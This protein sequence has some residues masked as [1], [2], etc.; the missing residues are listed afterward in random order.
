MDYVK[1]AGQFVESNV[2][3]AL[4][5]PY[6]MAV[7]KITLV[8]YAAQLAPRAPEYLQSLFQNTFVKMLAVF[9]IAYIAEK[10]LQ[11]AILM[12]II[13][14]FGMNLLSGRG[15]FESFADYSS[16]YTP[17]WSSTLIEPHTMIYPGCND[18]T[19]DDLYK[20][21]N[22]DLAKMQRT[23]EYSF[24]Q[25]IAQMK[26][27]DAKEKITKLAYAAG[28]PYNMS[29]DKPETA[30]YIATLLVNHGFEINDVCKP[31]Q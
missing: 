4:G 18:V 1:E 26:T 8:L 21:F 29:F 6:L 5:N 31:P 22:G 10:D 13:Y 3:Y 9:L 28:L 2:D 14:V 12:A 15:F 7:V 17:S 30:P 25:L 20:V 16:E 23:V 24:Q 11:L 27:E 19:M